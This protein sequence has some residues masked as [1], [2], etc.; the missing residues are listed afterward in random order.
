[1]ITFTGT[2][3]SLEFGAPS[4][5]D[6]AVQ[7]MRLCRF[8]GGCRL[9]WPV[10]M[11]SLVVA[12]ILPR[13]MEHHGLLH[14]AAE[15]AVGEVCRPFKTDA[16]RAVEE[17]IT[18]RIYAHLGLKMPTRREAELIHRADVRAVNAEG[19]TECGPRGYAEI[20]ANYSVDSSALSAIKNYL[21]VYEP[22]EAINPR[23]PWVDLFERRL[24]ASITRAQRIPASAR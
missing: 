5:Q 3:V 22:A 9:F 13:E 2:H 4:V 17:S 18:R 20:Q 24:R 6:I 11:H 16:A 10:G 12:D 23:G 8:G 15:I 1:M 7:L 21:K 19:A 14:D